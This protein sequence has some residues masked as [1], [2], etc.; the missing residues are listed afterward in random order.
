M[1]RNVGI[2]QSDAGEL[3]KKYIQDAYANMTLTS[4]YDFKLEG[5]VICGFM[6]GLLMPY[7]NVLSGF[8]KV[9]CTSAAL[10]TRCERHLLLGSKNTEVKT[11]DLCR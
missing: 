8:V 10:V 6:L 9:Q 4:R 5:I 1:F 7:Q 2:Q 3:P 11:R